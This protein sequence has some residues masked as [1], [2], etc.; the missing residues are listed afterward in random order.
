ML[1]NYLTELVAALMFGLLRIG[2]VMVFTPFLGSQSIAM[3]VK[4]ALTVSLAMLL[5]PAYAPSRMNLSAVGWG[6]TALSE[7]AVGLLLG[8]TLNFVLEAAQF[9]GQVTG[10]QMG[11]S[12]VS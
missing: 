7:A 9:A 3:P 6:K 8:L 5:Y 1:P 10:I 4:A 2:G 11:F 12:L